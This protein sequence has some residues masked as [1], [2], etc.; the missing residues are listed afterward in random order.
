ML[1]PIVE[2]I[3]AEYEGKQLAKLTSTNSH[4]L[5]QNIMWQAYRL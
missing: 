3:A 2:E 4:S 1:A 5:Q